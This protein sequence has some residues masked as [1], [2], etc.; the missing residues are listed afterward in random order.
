MNIKKVLSYNDTD[1]YFYEQKLLCATKDGVFTLDCP[2]EIQEEILSQ[3]IE[4]KR[5][6]L[7]KLLICNSSC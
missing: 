6:L 3:T 2:T 5:Y 1:Y 4:N 7:E